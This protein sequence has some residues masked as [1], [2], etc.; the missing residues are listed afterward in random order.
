M[1]FV[2]YGIGAVGGALAAAL[3][4][5]GADVIAIARGR[6]LES[7]QNGPIVL[8]SPAGSVSIALR[9]V[10][11]PEHAD[12]EDGDVVLL[13]VK[14]QHT[15]QVAADLA[16]TADRDIPII[17]FQNGVANE[18]TLLRL[19]RRVYGAVVMMPTTYVEPGQVSVYGQPRHGIIDIGRFPGG[20]DDLTGQ[21]SAAL[22]AANFDSRPIPDIMRWKYGKLVGNLT[23]AIEAICGLGTRGGD[24]GRMVTEEGVRVLD[25]AGI[26]YASEAEED[27]RRGE[28]VELDLAGGIPRRGASSWQS[29]ARGSGSIETDY[30]NGEISLLGRLH[31]IATP[32]NDIVQTLALETAR[33]GAAPGSIPEREILD[34]LAR[35]T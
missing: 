19:F 2:V 24:L 23:N 10:A 32:A 5:S 17:C 34:M 8:H 9:S 12:L 4:G 25:G 1:R 22:T 6:Q 16:A 26:A 3:S 33:S 14:S 11:G 20:V 18:P 21:V 7:L 13:T 15:A 31:D 29:L 30:L 35:A 27:E 28:N